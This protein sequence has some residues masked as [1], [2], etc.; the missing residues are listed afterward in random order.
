MKVLLVEDDKSLG[1]SL[2]E[3]L[4]LKEIDVFWIHDERKLPNIIK[5]SAFDVIILD[6]ILNFSRGEDLI[7]YIRDKNIKTP[8]LILTAKNE[9]SSKEECFTKG[10]DDYLV[11][12]FDPKELYLRILAL[13]KRKQIESKIKMGDIVINIDSKTILKNNEEIKISKTAW[14]LLIL[15]VKRR[16]EILDTDTILNYVWGG[17]A[18]GDEVVRTYIKELRKI[19]PANSIIT[20]KGRGYKLS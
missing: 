5:I 11:K 12:P 13:S 9:L 19:L 7:T 20:Y 15:L 17:K 3:F 1:E 4:K 6:L 2:E 18:V 16:G 10:A 8:I 14:E